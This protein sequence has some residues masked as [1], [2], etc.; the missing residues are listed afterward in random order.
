MQTVPPL[1][2][3]RAT[4]LC[5]L[6]VVMPAFSGC[7]TSL[8]AHRVEKR[9]V[10]GFADAL[11][12]ADAERLRALASADFAQ[13]VLTDQEAID[14]VK[15]A[16]PVTGKLEVVKVKEIDENERR[17]PA[18]PE[19]LVTIKDERDW[20]T[21][22]R[23]IQDPQ[24]GKW[25]IDEILITAKQK[26]ISATRTV[27]EQVEFIT[28]VQAFADAWRS[29]PREQRLAGVTDECRAELEPLPDEVLDLFAA[30]IFPESAR[31]VD[32]DATMDDDI[33]IVR[34]RRPTG[35]VYLNL[36]RHDERWLVDDVVLDAGKGSGESIRSLRE[37]AVAYAAAAKF[38]TAYN[39][40]DRETLKTVASE[41]FFDA[42]LKSANLASISLPPAAAGESGDLKVV[43]RQGELVI[44]GPERTVKLALVRVDSDDDPSAMT[45]FRVED[46]TIYE[47][48]GNSKKRL[49]SALVAEPMAQLFAD[50]LIARNVGQLRMMSTPGFNEQVWNHVTP[51]IAAELPL[52]L[53]QPGEREL[54]SVTHNGAATEVTMMQAGRAMTCVMR[55]DGGAVKVD[56]VLM[57]VPEDRPP[58]IRTTLVHMLP[59]LRLKT[60][61]AAGS[62]DA[63]RRDCSNDFNRLIWSQL[64][65]VPPAANSA[66]RFLDAPLDSL[67][68]S[69]YEATVKLGDA[70]YG[71]MITLIKQGSAWKVNDLQIVAGPKPDDRAGLKAMLR[72]G[73]AN[74]T[75]FAATG[76]NG[77]P[78][79]TADAASMIQQVNYETPAE[80]DQPA[81]MTSGRPQTAAPRELPAGMPAE[82]SPMP[83]AESP[84]QSLKEPRPLDLGLSEDEAPKPRTIDEAE[85]AAQEGSALPFEEPLW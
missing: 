70:N 53:I 9:T 23:L 62:L 5:A 4:F 68:L 74:G 57:A 42:T 29:G 81:P 55:D 73:L 56:D 30:R 71:S 49:A 13:S 28:V 24:S 82:S 44:A 66:L 14:Q 19:K 17:D 12:E 3:A 46:V 83:T 43:G 31:S 63:I 32:P 65:G 22:H 76:P 20:K 58:S 26:G 80:P 45:D 8:L 59:V 69:E 36:E 84:P 1:L 10:N 50:A 27:S 33:A 77:T 39:A 67:Q 64:R 85:A 72:T 37:S 61:L 7:Q 15:R 18:V 51:E 11:A 2:A 6:A 35:S 16:W 79:K 60:A 78:P 48:G 41:T 40:G 38:L 52:N 54:L 25:V 21:D 75:L 34:L 47:E